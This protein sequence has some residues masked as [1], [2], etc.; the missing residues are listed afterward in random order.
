MYTFLNLAENNLGLFSLKAYE[1]RLRVKGVAEELIK[2]LAP[3]RFLVT[4]VVIQEH[5]KA[6]DALPSTNLKI[7]RNQLLAH[8]SLSAVLEDKALEKKYPIVWTEVDGIFAKL[9]EMMNYYYNAWDADQRAW[10]PEF[11]SEITYVLDAIRG[12]NAR[13]RMTY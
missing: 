11:E 8:V 4:S 12:H 9:L 10:G 1:N 6:V 2:W 7:W 3:K 13:T 5:R